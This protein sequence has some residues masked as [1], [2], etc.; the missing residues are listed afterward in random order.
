MNKIFKTRKSAVIALSICFFIWLICFSACGNKAIFDPGSFNFTHVHVSD[1]V[2]GHCF[3]V[4][5]W[6]ENDGS[7]IEVRTDSDNGMFCSEGT[8]Q[9]FTS[10]TACPYCK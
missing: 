5:K 9:L 6:W 8:Y 7:G 4:K 3:E 2:E 1:N 10:K